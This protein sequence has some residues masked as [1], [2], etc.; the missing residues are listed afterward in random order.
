MTKVNTKRWWILALALV[1]SLASFL[2][3]WK[4]FP[5]PPPP[6]AQD[7]KPGD[8][9]PKDYFTETVP[10]TFHVEKYREIPVPGEAFDPQVSPNGDI[11]V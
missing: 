11:S 8:T 4:F 10:I 5:S 3:I 9:V 2:T 6:P 7:V 1:V